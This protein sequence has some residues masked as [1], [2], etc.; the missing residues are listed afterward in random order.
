MPLTN[1]ERK[2]RFFTKL[3]EETEKRAIRNEASRKSKAKKKQTQLG[4]ATQALRAVTSDPMIPRSQERSHEEEVNRTPLSHD[5]QTLLM[6][7]HERKEARRVKAMELIAKGKVETDAAIA[8]AQKQAGEHLVACFQDSNRKLLDLEAK[9]DEY[10]SACMQ[11]LV[12]GLPLDDISEGLSQL[13]LT[14]ILRDAKPAT[15]K[16]ASDGDVFAPNGSTDADA[17]ASNGST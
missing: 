12:H 2:D 3:A 14:E 9:S 15:A 1:K 7:I 6:K 5:Q 4:L 16:P 13:N 17:F 11:V 10:D 8:A